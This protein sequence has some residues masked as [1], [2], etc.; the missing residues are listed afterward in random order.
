MTLAPRLAAVTLAVLLAAP[1]FAQ[2]PRNY[3]RCS[4]AER[5]TAT[6]SKTVFPTAT[7]EMVEDEV[8]PPRPQPGPG[9]FFLKHGLEKLT[10]PDGTTLE[11]NQG[12]CNFHGNAYRFRIAKDTTPTSETKHWLDKA[13]G[14]VSQIEKGNVDSM[15]DLPALKRVLQTRVADPKARPFDAGGSLDGIV[16]QG[17]GEDRG[18]ISEAYLVTINQRRE[19]TTLVSIQYII[20]PL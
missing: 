18:R 4:A 14:L 9:P 17:G 13:I 5:N 2:P 10:L 20:G 12:G 6:L 1:A 19:D 3:A 7:F 8:T 15:V 11:I 16:P